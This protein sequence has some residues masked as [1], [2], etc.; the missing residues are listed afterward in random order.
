[1]QRK[2]TFCADLAYMVSQLE[3][4]TIKLRAAI[5]NKQKYDEN[6]P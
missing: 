2:Q 3:K 6:I 1:M 4:Q 5:D